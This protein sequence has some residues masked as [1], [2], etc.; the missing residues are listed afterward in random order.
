MQAILH[1]PPPPSVSP[2][3][4]ATPTTTK[5]LALPCSSSI[6]RLLKSPRCP[7][8]KA[9]NVT[10]DP[11][12]VDYSSVTSVFPAEAC[13]TIGGEACDVEMYPEVKLKPEDRNNTAKTT[14]EQLDRDYLEYDS[15]KTV[16]PGE[17]C[18]DL[19]GEFCEPEYQ[20]GVH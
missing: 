11:T 2:L 12:A 14:S 18:D 4:L 17:A 19:G 8:L 16:F 5:S 3:A 15:P 1:L 10:D 7:P 9:A 13:D 20:R 6:P